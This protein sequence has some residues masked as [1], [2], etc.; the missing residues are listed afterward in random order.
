MSHKKPTVAI[1]G[2]SNDRTKFGN[3]AVRAFLRQGWDV[4]PVN[5][6]ATHVEGLAAYPSVSAIPLPRL[7]RVSFYV[8]ARIGQSRSM[9]K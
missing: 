5:P 1:V 2:A 9:A 6:S 4:Y 8:P 7:D 3:K